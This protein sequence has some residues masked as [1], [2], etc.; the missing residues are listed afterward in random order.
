MSTIF[1]IL[2]ITP[3][4]LLQSCDKGEYKKAEFN[5]LNKGLTE[6][7]NQNKMVLL[8]FDF[9]G[10]PIRSTEKLYAEN[11]ISE[12]IS[13]RFITVTLLVD[14][15]VLGKEIAKMQKEK[16]GTNYQP[17]YYILSSNNKIIKGPKGYTK[18]EDFLEFLK[19]N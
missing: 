1:K 4:L 17:A 7:F 13:E 11:E 6:A 16:Y 15:N 10:N 18:S 19:S 8:A 12:I 14:D 2:L 3:A 5:N 9:N